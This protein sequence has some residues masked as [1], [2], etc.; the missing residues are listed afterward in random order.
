VF[1]DH[2]VYRQACLRTCH[3]DMEGL[4]D[5]WAVTSSKHVQ[6]APRSLSQFTD[7]CHSVVYIQNVRRHR[8]VRYCDRC[9]NSVVFPSVCRSYFF[10]LL[11]SLDG[12][13]CNL[14]DCH[15]NWISEKPVGIPIEFPQNSYR[16]LLHNKPRNL[17]YL[18]PTA[19]IISSDACLCCIS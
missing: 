14:Q 6:P 4:T 15:G 9:Y 5:F 7:V 1:L 11:K 12:M 13:R 8:D 10:T 16:H 18:Y 2:P 3:T 19:R 17:S